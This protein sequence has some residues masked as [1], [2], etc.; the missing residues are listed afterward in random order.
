[1]LA[2]KTATD[3]YGG[4]LEHNFFGVLE[5][6]DKVSEAFSIGP[7]AGKKPSSG[8]W[9]GA[10][11]GYLSGATGDDASTANLVAADNG[12][13]RGMVTITVNPVAADEKLMAEFKIDNIAGKTAA[14][15][16]DTVFG[17]MEIGRKR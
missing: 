3:L 15:V 17:D 11:T 4:W 14:D 9:T 2:S 7:P 12:R 5:N 10:L 16:A 1:M 8:I 6:V 13:V